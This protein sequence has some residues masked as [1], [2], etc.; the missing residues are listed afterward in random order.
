MR[1]VFKK[2][3][4]PWSRIQPM[5]M[6]LFSAVFEDTGHPQNTHEYVVN[7]EKIATSSNVL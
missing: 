5:K 7:R 1:A 4:K 6:M 2:M 3:M